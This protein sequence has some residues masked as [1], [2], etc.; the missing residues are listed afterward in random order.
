MQRILFWRQK[1][2]QS[3]HLGN[4]CSGPGERGWLFFLVLWGREGVISKHGKKWEVWRNV[5]EIEWQNL[6]MGWMW[7]MRKSKMTILFW[8]RSYTL[9]LFTT[10]A[11]KI[12]MYQPSGTRSR[13]DCTVHAK[14][15]RGNWHISSTT[16]R[17]IILQSNSVTW[18]SL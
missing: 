5:L 8:A 17:G 15:T 10:L 9:N 1:W 7:R 18:E 14:C 11:S 16:V 6:L 13:T 4:D 12:V 2:K 3:E